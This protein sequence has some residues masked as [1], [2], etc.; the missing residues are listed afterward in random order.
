MTSTITL[1]IPRGLSHGEPSL[2]L[3]GRHVWSKYCV[4]RPGTL[5][6]TWKDEAGGGLVLGMPASVVL[7]SLRTERGIFRALQSG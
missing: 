3:S 4:P 1:R 7:C 2:S 5:T 6:V